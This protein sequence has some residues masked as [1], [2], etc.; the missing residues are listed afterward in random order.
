MQIERTRQL[1]WWFA[2]VAC[3]AV[4]VGACND[5]PNSPSNNI[6]AP[7]L[8][9][10]TDDALASSP[11]LLTVSNVSTSSSGARTYDFQVAD[12]QAAVSGSGGGALLA[13]G[14][15]IAEGTLQTSYRLEAALQPAKRYYWRS[16]VTQNGAAGTWSAAF[17]F[18]TAAVPNNPPL[19]Q[20]ITTN[21][22]RAEVNADIQVTAVVQDQETSPANLTYEWSATGGTFNGSTA[23]VVWRAPATVAMAT[24]VLTLTVIER[25]TSVD[26]DGR[27]Q[28]RE[29]R[30]TGSVEVHLNNS[31]DEL[32]RL[33][34]TFLDDFVHSERSPETCV[35]NFSDNCTGKQ[36]ELSDIRS[37]RA[38]FVNDPA[39]SSFSIRSI[40]YNTSG[41]VATGA[42]FATVLAPC[43]FAATRKSNGA[44]GIASGT[45]RLTNVYENFQWRLCESNFLSPQGT[46]SFS[47]IFKILIQ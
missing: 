39:R 35:R 21:S 30:T 42:T 5:S 28:N 6:P 7:A 44:F 38:E 40:S 8:V 2:T 47:K 1:W 3:A 26:A 41:N 25:Y 23:S 18:Q 22:N 33:A 29:N 12:N 24:H 37:N 27:T 20:S 19:I 32:S 11:V 46:F 43:N 9:S 15:G 17:R 16:R 13:S 34:L 4:L 36:D 10:P 45:C 14:T 31:S